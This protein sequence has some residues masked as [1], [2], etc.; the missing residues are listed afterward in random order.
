[1]GSH[2]P[3]R[4]GPRAGQPVLRIPAA[5]PLV[6]TST[7][8]RSR[9]ASSCAV[10]PSEALEQ[11]RLDGVERVE[12]R[13]AQAQ[14]GGEVGVVGQQPVV[15]GD[16]QH[17]RNRPVVL[18]LQARQHRVADLRAGQAR[19]VGGD[20]EV[21]LGERH[22][23]VVE[24]HAQQPA[25]GGEARSSSQ[26]ASS[27]RAHD[28]RAEPTPYQAG[29]LMRHCVQANTHGIARRSRMSCPAARRAGGTRC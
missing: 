28:V 4:D 10:D 2:V 18:L 9:P 19:V 16:A 20:R 22:L 13:V 25:A 21:R 29:R 11:R 12:V 17:R 1:M 15:P 14:H 8:V 3:D 5:M 6:A 27:S 26:R 24:G 23:D 7:A